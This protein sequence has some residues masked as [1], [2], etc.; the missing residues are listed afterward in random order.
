M[1]T[2]QIY[3]KYSCI[4]RIKHVLFAHNCTLFISELV[5]IHKCNVLS[6]TFAKNSNFTDATVKVG[7][8]ENDQDLFKLCTQL[9]S[10]GT[11][12]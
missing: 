2:V 8:R 7:A 3:Y 11:I 6:N 10:A 5:A 12:T 4:I 9:S 1:V